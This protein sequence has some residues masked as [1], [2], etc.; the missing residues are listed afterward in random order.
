MAGVYL[1]RHMTSGQVVAVK[2]ARDRGCEGDY[3]ER[4]RD[5]FAREA[6]I[7]SLLRPCRHIV[8]LLASGQF[9]ARRPY[10]VMEHVDGWDLEREIVNHGPFSPTEVANLLTQV[11][12]GLQAA[13]D[14]G[15]AHLDL[16]PQNIMLRRGQSRRVVLVDF[17]IARRRGDSR[18]V[19]GWVEGSPLYMAPEQLAGDDEHLG[20]AADIHALGLLA[21][22]LLS[23]RLPFDLD[24]RWC[25][26]DLIRSRLGR[27][28]VALANRT[29]WLPSDLCL[30]VDSCLAVD[31]IARPHSAAV[32]S[33]AFRHTAADS[34]DRSAQ[35]TL[36]NLRVALA[37]TLPL[38]TA[39]KKRR[40]LV[41][42]LEPRPPSRT[43]HH[44]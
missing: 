4:T 42:G 14:L 9:C 40:T 43:Q 24:Q 27:D 6:E 13:H 8:S 20:P 34:C 30:L 39:S 28:P 41:K 31:P 19:A 1:G 25:I 32:F 7:L 11:C 23:G 35:K 26:G 2:V 21:Y 29:P 18:K 37:M 10:L 17:G 44:S 12:A 5:Q 15:I 38:A 33:H 3:L 22:L 36:L 16:K